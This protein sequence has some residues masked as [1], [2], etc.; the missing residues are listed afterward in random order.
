MNN[1]TWFIGP[2]ESPETKYSFVLA[3]MVLHNHPR[4]SR[5]FFNV[6]MPEECPMVGRIADVRS[7]LGK[8][9][10]FEVEFVAPGA[11]EK[12]KEN[13]EAMLMFR[14]YHGHIYTNDVDENKPMLRIE[15]VDKK[16]RYVDI[17]QVLYEYGQIINC[18]IMNLEGCF[19]NNI[20]KTSAYTA[21]IFMG[22]DEKNPGSESSVWALAY[23]KQL[24]AWVNAIWLAW[25]L[26]VSQRSLLMAIV[27]SEIE[28]SGDEPAEFA[29]YIWDKYRD[30]LFNQSLAESLFKRAGPYSFNAF[31]AGNTFDE[32]LMWRQIDKATDILL[33]LMMHEEN[34]AEAQMEINELKGQGFSVNH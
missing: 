15:A 10:S 2:Q 19:E 32:V 22:F 34:V 28:D 4:Y 6:Q 5:L 27:L 3:P 26:G 9:F 7:T 16:L 25:M 31:H 18:Q 8:M 14:R 30:Y 17:P 33:Q 12:L 24:S 1:P 20:K 29:E 13:D 11:L 21:A 23:G